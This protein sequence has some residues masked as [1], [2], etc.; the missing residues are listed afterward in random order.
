MVERDVSLYS[1]VHTA[2][3]HGTVLRSE[4]GAACVFCSMSLRAFSGTVPHPVTPA[5]FNR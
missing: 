3:S 5:W 4:P 1:C 2:A